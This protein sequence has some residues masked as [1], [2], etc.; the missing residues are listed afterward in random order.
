MGLI[1]GVAEQCPVGVREL[2][3]TFSVSPGSGIACQVTEVKPFGKSGTGGGR[4]V[5]ASELPMINP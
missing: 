3:T 5:F 4:V 1:E 2:G